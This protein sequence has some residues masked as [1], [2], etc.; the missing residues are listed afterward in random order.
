M[1]LNLSQ[2]TVHWEP[3]MLGKLTN[4]ATSGTFGPISYDI[5]QTSRIVAPTSGLNDGQTTVQGTV[6]GMV[7]ALTAEIPEPVTLGLV[8]CALVSF[9]V[10]RRKMSAGR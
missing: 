7:V 9:V 3:A 4:N 10:V 8:G 6:R 2:I 1:A 5:N